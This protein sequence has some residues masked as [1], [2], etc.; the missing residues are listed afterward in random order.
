MAAQFEQGI[1]SADLLLGSFTVAKSSGEVKFTV[2][3]SY[4][5]SL[6]SVR[7]LFSVVPLHR[8]AASRDR[9]DDSL[10]GVELAGDTEAF[11]VRKETYGCITVTAFSPG[12]YGLIMTADKIRS[13]RGSAYAILKSVRFCRSQCLTPI[14]DESKEHRLQLPNPLPVKRYIS[15]IYEQLI[16]E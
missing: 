10:H 12:S 15:T 8:L 16:G 4:L 1:G 11:K 6:P 5:I 2:N 14:G 13:T 7:V 9:D 3:Y